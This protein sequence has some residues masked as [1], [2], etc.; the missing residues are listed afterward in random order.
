MVLH[1]SEETHSLTI[2]V[3]IIAGNNVRISPDTADSTDA[4][5]AIQLLVEACLFRWIYTKAVVSFPLSLLPRNTLALD[6]N[7]LFV[8]S[9]AMKHPSYAAISGSGVAGVPFPLA[10]FVLCG[11]IYVARSIDVVTFAEVTFGT[12]I[13]SI[14]ILEFIATG[15]NFSFRLFSSTMTADSRRIQELLQ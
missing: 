14:I 13:L 4:L 15:P 12:I 11:R 3:E 5:L 6:A 10:A 9:I 8:V 2:V 7:T 1:H